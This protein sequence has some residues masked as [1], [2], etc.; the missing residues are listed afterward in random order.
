M[1]LLLLAA[2]TLLG[3]CGVAWAQAAAAGAA[4]AAA[5]AP[6]SWGLRAG[7]EER[8]RFEDWDN[9]VD[10][11]D[12]AADRR[13]QWRFRTRLWAT[14]EAWQHLSFGVMLTNESK[15]QGE[16][17]APF[18]M[19]ETIFEALWVAV[20]PR[21]GV[22]VKIGRQDLNKA[23]GFIWRD[24]TPG[25]GARTD[26]ANVLD[27]SFVVSRTRPSGV[28]STP[29]RVSTL[30]VIVAS[31]PV[32]DTYLPI[33]HDQHRRLVEW[34]ER[35]AGVYYSDRRRPGLDVDAYYFFKREANDRRPPTNAQFQPDRDLNTVGVHVRQQAGSGWGAWGDVAVQFGTQAPDTPVRG[36]G[37]SAGV[38]RQLRTA[39]APTFR[40]SYMGLSGDSPG[41]ATIE[42]WDPLVSRWPL[43]NE[44]LV[45]AFGPE[46]GN[47]YWS[48]LGVLK[49]E[50][51]VAP[52]PAI[53]M[54]AAYYK[55]TAFHAFNGSTSVFGSGTDRGHML[56]ARLD[57]TLNARLKGYLL[58]ERLWPGDFYAH[59]DPSHLLRVEF[60]ASW[61]RRLH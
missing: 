53:G 30:E 44:T 46:H 45:Y 11:W 42:G 27:A 4:A 18:A 34:D 26:Y 58:Y 10:H 16:P 54:R 6:S 14:G 3:P 35:L 21:P 9:I 50:A 37:G 40:A 39:W 2:G 8:F 15:G 32:Y 36:L 7:V 33:I 31:D 59:R 12:G 29:P 41:S 47:A 56:Q 5:P 51:T 1:L 57:A 55:L 43:V 24:G 48:N 20:T 23:D 25:D 60:T 19:D 13:V 61:Q 17:R 38:Q 28:S 22:T 49:A 52:S